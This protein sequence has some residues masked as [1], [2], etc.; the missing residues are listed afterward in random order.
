MKYAL[1]IPDGAADKPLDELDGK[2]PI[3]AA[4]TP[5]MDRVARMGR[6]G[7]VRTT[8]RGYKAGSDICCMALFGYPVRELHT[9]RAP[10][11]AAALGIELDE[12]DWVFRLN[13][14]TTSADGKMRDHSAGHITD[15]EASVLLGSLRAAWAEQEPALAACFDLRAGVS[16][17]HI[18]V[19]RSG[20]DYSALETT[21]PHEILDQPFEGHL[22]DRAGG[23][24]IARLMEI[25]AEVFAAHPVNVA[26]REA[27]R[28]EATTAWV[29]G[30]GKKP[31]LPRFEEAFGKRAAIITA[32][33]LLAGISVYAGITRLEVPGITGYHD[34]DYAEKGRRGAAALDDFDLVI[35]HVEAPD[36]ASHQA[37]LDT[38]IA[39]IE[40][41]DT[42]VVGPVVEKL[43]SF[44]VGEER[45]I[46]TGVGGW[47]VLV[48][49][50]H[51][52]CVGTRQ[53]DDTPVP[54]AMAGSWVRGLVKEDFGETNAQRADLHIAPGHDLMEYFLYS[55]LKRSIN[56]QTS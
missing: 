33:D 54:F 23:E 26:R 38:K 47:R 29:W 44:G 31:S 14:V 3:E 42:H 30:Q 56:R 13:L 17:R 28:G 39:A 8:P 19:D 1:I 12:D 21:P 48:V 25:S 15:G 32:V 41:I 24:R 55:G 46:D 7:T 11:E 51:Y 53:H 49:P 2:T 4:Q 20:F 18:L 36:E 45:G 10:L 22:P 16:Y 37:D 35:V 9:G 40:A 43:E 34:T 27:G 52:T 50:D 6:Q 5:N